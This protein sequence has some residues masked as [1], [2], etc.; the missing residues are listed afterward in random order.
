MDE[1]RAL[2]VQDREEGMSIS[3]LAEIYGVSRKTVYKWLGRHDEEGLAGRTGHKPPA[4]PFAQPIDGRSKEA[5]IVAARHRWR[6]G[7]GKLRVKLCQQDS[8]TVW[9]AVSTIAA[10][11]KAQGPGGQSSQ[12]A[13]CSRSTPSVYCCGRA[14]R[15]VEHRFQRLVSLRTARVNPLTISDGCS[16]LLLRCQHVDR[17]GYEDVQPVFDA[18]FRSMT[19]WG[20]ALR[21]RTAVCIGGSRWAEQAVHL[22]REVG[23][24]G[25]AEQAWMSA[26]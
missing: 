19:A 2:M 13:T 15:G 25:G 23:D 24:C 1:Q 9:P 8:Q 4:S 16:R 5:A 26:G 12:P 10:V 14:E 17:P 21:Q 6:W 18:A 11:L 7:A 3:E 20:H 22:V